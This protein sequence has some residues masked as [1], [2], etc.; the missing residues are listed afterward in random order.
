VET[1]GRRP[2][3]VRALTR[4]G[5]PAGLDVVFPTDVHTHSRRQQIYVSADGRIARHDCV[6]EVVGGWAHGAHFWE[7]YDASGTLAIARRRRVVFR[8]GGPPM[9]FRV[10]EVQL[11][12]VTCRPSR[13]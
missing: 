13:S 8:A 3:L 5:V 2:I 11:G 7:D 9:P 12:E 1:N 4:G 10:L 6:A